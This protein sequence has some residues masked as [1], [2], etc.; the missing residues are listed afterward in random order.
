MKK[1]LE[2]LQ[3]GENDFR[4]DTDIDLSKNLRIINTLIPAIALALLTSQCEGKKQSILTLIRCLSIADLSV[5]L[6]RKDMVSLLD[7][8][9]ENLEIIM[10]ESRKEILSHRFSHPK[11]D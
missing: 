9:S 5:C 7:E 8:M 2:V 1:I 3:F 10:E 4:F 6:R 11:S